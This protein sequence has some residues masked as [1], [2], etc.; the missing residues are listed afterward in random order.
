MK[1]IHARG[2]K[3]YWGWAFL[4]PAAIPVLLIFAYPIVLNTIF[5]LTDKRLLQEE[6]SFI[7]LANFAE[8]ASSDVFWTSLKNSFVWTIGSVIGQV[9]VGITAALLLFFHPKFQT[10]FRTALIVPWMM[11]IIVIAIVWRWL[12]NDLYGIVNYLIT[13]VGIS[14]SP[15]SVFG[16]GTSAMLNVIFVDVWRA[17]PL[18]ML[19]TI[20]GLQTI[21]REHFEVA[22]VEGASALQLFRYLIAPAIVGIV[23]IM[24]VLR[25]IWTFNDFARIYLL[26]GGG[27]GVSTQTVPILAYKVSWFSRDIGVG[28]AISVVMLLILLVLSAFYIRSMKLERGAQ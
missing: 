15:P 2:I 7:G 4:I 25:T 23:G 12:F 27:P 1:S 10:F 9:V 22:E 17:Y 6:Q 28:A 3:K 11:P 14:D 21:P 18:M 26:T 24:V 5:S 16:S 20:A 8:L 13:A 19:S